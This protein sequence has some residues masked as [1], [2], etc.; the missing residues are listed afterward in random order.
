MKTIHIKKQGCCDGLCDTYC[1]F[2]VVESG[3]IGAGMANYAQLVSNL[4]KTCKRAHAAENEAR[5]K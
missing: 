4:C 2:A 5:R 3:A 1:G